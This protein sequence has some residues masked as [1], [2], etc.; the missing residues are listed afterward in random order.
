MRAPWSSCLAVIVSGCVAYND[1]CQPLVDNPSERVAFIASGTELFLDRPNARHGNNALGQQAAD[2]F[3][4]VFKDTDRAVDFAVVN[5]GSLR[6]EGLCITRNIVGAGPLSNGVLH[7]I[8]LFENSVQAV[9]LTEKEVVD[10]FEHSAERLFA[11][12]AAIASPAGSFLQVSKE[13]EMT[14][15]CAQPPLSRVTALRVNGVTLTK[16]GSTSIDARRFRVASSSFI[17]AGGDGYTM[18]AG[19]G[20]DASRNLRN[21]QRFGGIDSNIVAAYLKQSEFNQSVD[22]GFRVEAG[23]I[24]FMNCSV[25]TRPSN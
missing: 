25:P 6:A 11:Q 19:K 2:A 10:M 4:W 12:P 7:E 1:Q 17:I 3:A 8:M 16:P 21:A 23:R 5:G 22:Q 24:T 15:D 18:L 20:D 9:D 13:I 14:I